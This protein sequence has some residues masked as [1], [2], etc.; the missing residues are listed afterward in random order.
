[1]T[2]MCLSLLIWFFVSGSA[3]ADDPKVPAGID[4][5][6]QPIAILTTGIDY[7]DPAI[8]ARLARDGEGELIGWDFTENDR[9]PFAASPNTTPPNWGGDGTVLVR[10]WLL[11]VSRVRKRPK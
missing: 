3:N 7:T 6:L 8:A 9:R 10:R 2:R 11:A 4:P 5:G 1:M